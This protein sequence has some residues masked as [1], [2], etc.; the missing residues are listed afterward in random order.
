GSLIGRLSEV[1]ADQFGDV[2]S[3]RRVLE[4]ELVHDPEAIT[5][6]KGPCGL[7]A[8]WAG[9][10]GRSPLVGIAVTVDPD[11]GEVAWIPLD[12]DASPCEALAGAELV[13]HDA[14]PIL[15]S[16][17]DLGVELDAQVFDTKIAAYLLDP[18]ENRYE[19]NELLGRYCDAELAVSEG[20]AEPGQLD[21]SGDAE[22]EVARTAA[23]EALGTAVLAP[24]LDAALEAQHLQR[25][26]REIEMPLVSVLA[27]MEHV[28]VGVDADELR[29]LNEHLTAECRRLEAAI[30]EDA[31]EQFNVNSTK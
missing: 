15:R 7:A 28:G 27:R 24:A 13:A 1:F 5:T 3:N 29:R 19:L 9:A 26:F 10:P 31:G 22:D 12:G 25:L 30:W 16:L 8:K 17:L 21:F 20:G 23:R 4:A 11:L 2:E 18:A 14:K 6:S